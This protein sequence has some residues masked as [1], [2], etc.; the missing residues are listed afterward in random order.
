MRNVLAPAPALVPA[1]L[2]LLCVGCHEPNVQPFGPSELPVP[3]PPEPRAIL[4]QVTTAAVA[5]E[6]AGTIVRFRVTLQVSNNEYTVA[7]ASVYLWVSAGTIQGPEKTNSD[8]AGRVELVWEAPR[9]SRVILSACAT[10]SGAPPC[11]PKVVMR[12]DT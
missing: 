2:V 5:T 10:Q 12:R 9:Q 11:L 8:L 4:Y 6:T 3:D 7:G 1:L